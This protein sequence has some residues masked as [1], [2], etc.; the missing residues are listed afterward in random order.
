MAV[1]SPEINK[2]PGTR[3]ARQDGSSGRKAII[4]VLLSGV[5]TIIVLVLT[6]AKAAHQ[7]DL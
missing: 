2:L 1:T 3:V 5:Y 6:N 4:A 7:E